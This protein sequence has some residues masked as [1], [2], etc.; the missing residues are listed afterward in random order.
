MQ[1]SHIAT[2]DEELPTELANLQTSEMDAK[3]SLDHGAKIATR[4]APELYE[5]FQQLVFRLAR[6]GV[7]FRGRKVAALLLT[8]CPHSRHFASAIANPRCCPSVSRAGPTPPLTQVY[9]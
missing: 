2:I 9:R 6:D 7:K 4:T 1:F 3:R 5:A 8:P